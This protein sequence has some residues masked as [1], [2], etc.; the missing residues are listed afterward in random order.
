[1]RGGDGS[2]GRRGNVDVRPRARETA[3]GALRLRPG[4]GVARPPSTVLG[5]PRRQRVVRLGRRPH[6]D[7]PPRRAR[8]AAAP[9]DPREELR[10]RR[11]LREDPRRGDPGRRSHRRGARLDGGRDRARGRRGEARVAGRRREGAAR[12][13]DGRDRRGVPEEDRAQGGRRD[14]LRRGEARPL[15][16]QAVH[17]RPA[18]LR[19]RAVR[20]VLRRRLRQLHV[21]EVRPRRG[22][23]A[24]VRERQA[25]ARGAF[26][27][28]GPEGRRRRRRRVR[29]RPSRQDEPARHRRDARVPARRDV[30]REARAAQGAARRC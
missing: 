20:G 26:P 19:P 14:P 6:P 21:S 16:L 29:V 25:G 22:L 28:G 30:A 17:R 11:L 8:L 4:R 23:H 5:A 2:V 27:R 10:P 13:Q 15:P 24:G 9:R 3:E 7:E 1:M 12:R 18:G